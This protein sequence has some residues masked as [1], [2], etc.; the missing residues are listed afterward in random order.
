MRDAPTGRI[1]VLLA[2]GLPR[3]AA[4][5]HVHRFTVSDTAS[6]ANPVTYDAACGECGCTASGCG[7]SGDEY[8]LDGYLARSVDALAADGRHDDDL[9]PVHHI[10]G[11]CAGLGR[12]VSER[13]GCVVAD[14][15]VRGGRSQR[16]DVRVLR[17]L[18]QLLA[19]IWRYAVRAGSGASDAGRAGGDRHG[20]R[21]APA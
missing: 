1:P 6:N 20:D 16:P 13:S 11:A 3:C 15:A 19:G 4:C 14:R 9:C 18:S 12:S 10:A 7:Y 5:Q 2:C 8:D 21:G 17:H